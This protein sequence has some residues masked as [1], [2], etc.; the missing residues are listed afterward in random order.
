MKTKQTEVIRTFDSVW[1]AI[2]DTPE[3][4]ENMKLRSALM[5]KISAVI[6]DRGWTQAEAAAHCKI[7]QPRVNELLRGK[8]AK[9]SLDALV[10]VASALGLHM[11][12]VFS[13]TSAP[14]ELEAA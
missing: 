9:F 2:S 14:A 7:T 8:I 6:K 13:E 4:A 10:N 11:Q 5:M 3:E 12:V 1:D